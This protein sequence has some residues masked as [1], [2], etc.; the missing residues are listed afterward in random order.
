MSKDKSA[1][2]AV[3]FDNLKPC[4][5]CGGKGDICMKTGCNV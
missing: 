1:G 2:M 4:P 3:A 5:F